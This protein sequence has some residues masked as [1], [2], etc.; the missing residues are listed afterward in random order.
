MSGK[1][2]ACRLVNLAVERHYYDLD[3]AAARGFVFD[4]RTGARVVEFV[5]RWLCHWK[6]EWAGQPIRLE[7]WQQWGLIVLFGWLRPDGMRRFRRAWWRIARKNGKS[8]LA[9]AIGLYLMDADDEPGA[10]IFAAATK[11]EQVTE[12]VWKDAWKMVSASPALSRRIQRWRS[13]V[14]LTCEETGSK[15]QA[16]GADEDTLD[17][18]HPHGAIVDEIH[19]HRTR[20]VWDKLETGMGARRQPLLFAIT[21]AGDEMPNTPYEELDT[22]ATSILEGFRGEKFVDDSWMVFAFELD[23]DDDPFDPAVWVKANPN[24][25]VSVKPEFLA[26]QATKAR[27]EPAFLPSFLRYHCNRRAAA[28]GEAAIPL[29]LWDACEDSGL[30]DADLSGRACYGGL[31]LS[32]TTDLTAFATLWADGDGYLLRAHGWCPESGIERRAREDGAQYAAWAAQGWLTATPGNIVDYQLLQAQLLYWFGRYSY[33]EIAY[34]RARAADVC[35]RLRDAGLPMVETPQGPVAFTGP[36]NRLLD[37]VRSGRLRHDGSP[38]LRWCVGNLRVRE[39]G[40][41]LWRKWKVNS[42]SRID[43]IDAGIMALSRALLG[44]TSG[45]VYDGRLLVVGG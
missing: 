19:A 23:A 38:L 41:G 44:G 5:E 31:D 4:W 43:L 40:S 14:T 33:A 13:S 26:E 1:Q 21:T 3:H 2:T 25:G 39:A 24:L 11:R 36:Y 8:L 32:T 34:D 16:L 15:F 42:R 7:P 22:Y 10:E 30:L 9:A 37:L 35:V 20:G 12:Y 18:L 17:A 29:D 6:A 27:N 28:G 45:D